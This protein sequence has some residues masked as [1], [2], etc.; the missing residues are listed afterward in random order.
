MA[1]L[2]APSAPDLLTAWERGLMQQ[3]VQRAL[4]LLQAAAPGMSAETLAQFSIGRR[5]GLLLSLREQI[6]GS[7]C[8]AVASCPACGQRLELGF[9]VADVRTPPPET[10]S[11]EDAGQAGEHALQVDGH[12]VRFR[13]PNSLDLLAV[14]DQADVPAA[15]QQLLTRCLLQADQVGE[16]PAGEQ[17]PGAV[18]EALGREMDRLDP[19]ARLQLNL[20]CPDCEHQWPAAFDPGDYLWHEVADWAARTLR[21]VHTLASA[22]GWREADILAMHPWRRQVYLELVR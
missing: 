15:R 6:F 11:G 16:A 12:A 3:P 7:Q 9:A 20:T 14:A 22:Y 17:L 18:V 1:T 21:D 19:Q 13:L 2:H 4:T 5:N 10:G 8:M